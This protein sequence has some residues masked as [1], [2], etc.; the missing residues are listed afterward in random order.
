MSTSTK[1]DWGKVTFTGWEDNDD[2]V[3]RPMKQKTLTQGE[4]VGPSDTA[5]VTPMKNGKRVFASEKKTSSSLKKNRVSKVLSVVASPAPLLKHVGTQTIHSLIRSDKQARTHHRRA[6]KDEFPFGS[7]VSI[8]GYDLDYGRF[9]EK[10]NAPMFFGVVEN[11]VNHDNADTDKLESD[12][13]IVRFVV[14][15]EYEW[16]DKNVPNVLMSSYKKNH[17]SLISYPP[18]RRKDKDA[19]DEVDVTRWFVKGR[20]G[21]EVRVFDNP[22]YG[23]GS[24]WCLYHQYRGELK[25]MIGTLKENH[26]MTMKQRRYRCY[27]DAVSLKWGALGHATRKRAGWCWENVVHVAFPEESG[28]YTGFKVC[29]HT[30]SEGEGDITKRE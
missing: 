3:S 29:N 8:N 21:W 10:R 6:A 4:P 16:Y 15:G 13:L 14:S 18:M 7:I 12:E 9:T 28:N 24:P 17:L 11:P 19:L 25:N 22:C 26:R 1:K 5:I 2:F 30:D 23:C 20:S 27:R